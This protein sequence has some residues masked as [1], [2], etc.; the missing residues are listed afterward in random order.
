MAP[1]RVAVARPA[2]HVRRRRTKIRTLV[3]PLIFVSLALGL[4]LVAP[5]VLNVASMQTEWRVNRLDSRLDELAGQRSSLR[6]Q[7][8]AL[9]SSQR[10][11]QEAVALGLAPVDR[12]EHF[13]LRD[14]PGQATAALP[15]DAGDWPADPA[16]SGG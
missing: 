16:A 13:E 9:S 1:Q 2:L 15:S 4:L 8:A 6:A 10:L 11:Q 7:A 3:A 12:I 5:L 14:A